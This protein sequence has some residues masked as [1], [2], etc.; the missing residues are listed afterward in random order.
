MIEKYTYQE[1][2]INWLGEIPSNWSLKRVRNFFI[3]RSEKVDDTFFLPLSVTKSGIIDKLEKVAKSKDSDNRKLVKKNDFVINSRSD[4][5]GSSGI[6]KRDGSVS[7]INIVLEPRCIETKFIEYLFKSNYF[8]EEFFRNGKGIHWDLWTTRWEQFKN[9][10][11]PIPS[12]IEQE[13]ISIYLDKKTQ[14]IEELIL[15]IKEKKNLIKESIRCHYYEVKIKKLEFNY[16]HCEWF[17]LVPKN[18]EI[19]KF[20]QLFEPISINNLSNE[21]LLSVTQEKGVVYRDEQTRDVVN[22]SG[23]LST[24]KLVQPGDVIISLRSADGGL[25]IS[26]IRGLVSPAYTVLRPK[27]NIDLNYYKILFKSQNFIIEMN[28]YIK[29]IRDGKNIYFEDIKNVLIPFLP[30]KNWDEKQNKLISQHSQLV[31]SL[32]I[33]DKKIKLLMEYKNSLISSAVTGKIRIS[34]EMI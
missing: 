33:F 4:R 13:N 9:I 20:K 12:I 15:K 28:R 27:K 23:D 16:H 25:E 31:K 19:I 6:A 3:E 32:E 11:I 10:Y 8:A 18:W 17:Q 26:D 34:K 7:L 29:G 5:K 1:T 22:P 2:N 30:I 24:Y 21:R 14:K